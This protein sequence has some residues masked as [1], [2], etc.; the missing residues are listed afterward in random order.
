ME[1]DKWNDF[2]SCDPIPK[3]YQTPNIRLF[4]AKLH[5]FEEESVE[6][7]IDWTM[8]VNE[9]SILTQNIYRKDKTFSTLK[10][11][12]K[13]DFGYEYEK[14]IDQALRTL[15]RIDYYLDSESQMKLAT[16]SLQQDIMSRQ[17]AIP[18]AIQYFFDRYTYRILC[19]EV[20]YMK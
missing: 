9:N 13:V 19:S 18:E 7:T 1:L 17:K 11:E 14:I 4:F 15:K 16:I 8:A 12:T 10:E 6:R 5:F 3:A 20:A 2:V